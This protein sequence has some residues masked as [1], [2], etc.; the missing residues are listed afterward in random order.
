MA[1]GWA[2]FLERV[3]KQTEAGQLDPQAVWT[4]FLR[5]SQ[6]SPRYKMI[7][8]LA[9]IVQKAPADERIVAAAALA[10]LLAQLE[11]PP[12]WELLRP[13][14]LKALEELLDITDPTSST[15]LT[16]LL[17]PD[18]TE[19]VAAFTMLSISRSLLRSCGRYELPYTARLCN[20]GM[21]FSMMTYRREL[22]S[23]QGVDKPL[24]DALMRYAVACERYAQAARALNSAM[25]E[26]LFEGLDARL[27]IPET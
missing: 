19:T 18:R 23:R 21:L 2:E 17:A 25:G 5:L 27:E 13:G 8:P 4:E 14:L 12:E 9:N 16:A 24:M 6:Q 1:N 7:L 26:V 22:Q 20:M 3:G 10:V 11:W 15:S